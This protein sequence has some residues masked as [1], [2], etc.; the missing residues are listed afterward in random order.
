[1]FEK[2]WLAFVTTFK[3]ARGGPLTGQSGPHLEKLDSDAG[4][5]ELEEGGDQHDVPD[6]ADGNEHALDHV[7]ERQG[8]SMGTGAAL[9]H[10]T[11]LSG[12][13]GNAS[14]CLLVQ[15]G[16]WGEL[17]GLPH[18][19]PH[20][21]PRWASTSSPIWGLSHLQPFGSVDGSQWSEHPQNSQ[22]LHH[23]D[24]AGPAGST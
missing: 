7:L 3:L 18:P 10:P 20:G 24:G 21:W 9:L 16:Q 13:P 11:T 1:M 6:G 22:Y 8:R 5:Y 19:R 23:R 14:L 15:L 17:V 2:K 4:K 12:N